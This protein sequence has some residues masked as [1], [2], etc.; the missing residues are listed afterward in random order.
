MHYLKK[1]PSR[2]DFL[3]LSALASMGIATPFSSL[4]RM[5]AI[6]NVLPKPAFSDYK[7]MVCLF[8]HGGNDSYNMLMPKTGQAYTDYQTTR[9][10]LA[11]DSVDMLGI[12]GDVYGLHPDMPAIQQM[13]GAN[14][15]AFIANTGALVE[16]TTKQQYLDGAASLPLGLFSHLDQ[17][18]HF[19]SAL[20]NMRSNYGWA[21]KIADMIGDQNGNQNIPLNVSFSGSN[22]FQYGLNNSEFSMNS[23]GPLMP[24]NWDAT[25]GDNP[26]RKAA[27]DSLINTSYADMYMS[28]Y[29]DTFKSAI[30][31]A[32]EFRAAILNAFDFTTSFSSHEISENFEMIAKTIS[33][34]DDLDFQRQIFWIRYHGWDHHDNLLNS[35]SDYLTV[36]NNALA[37]FNSALKEIVR[38]D[39]VTTFVVS[40][41]SRKLTSNGNGTDHAWGGNMMAMGGAV[42]GGTIYGNYPSLSLSGPQLIHNGTIIPD[43]AVDSMFAELAMWYGIAPSDLTTLFPNLGNFHD[44]PT[45]SNT[46]PPIGFMQLT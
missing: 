40:E 35:H 45:L 30:E 19:Q 33:V 26:E 5:K 29:T 44:V 42:N 37:E 13:Y 14:E 12:A 31:G 25:W 16:P 17:F 39:D 4:T 24:S 11:H 21:G 46:K 6:N 28:S 32:E 36:I 8:L 3:R 1:K 15:L 38:F 23:E 9:S 43:T 20:P 27:I 18:N 22:I 10:N 41:F 2:R 34:Q 7:A